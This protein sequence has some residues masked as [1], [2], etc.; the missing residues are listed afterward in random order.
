MKI[1][2]LHKICSAMDVGTG[3]DGLMDAGVRTNEDM[4]RCGALQAACWE[5][6]EEF[7][8]VAG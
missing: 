6:M 5:T 7:G 8:R 1:P 4:G 3:F 2:I